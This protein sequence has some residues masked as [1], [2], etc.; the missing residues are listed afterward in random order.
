MK[1]AHIHTHTHTR[2]HAHTHTHTHTQKEKPKRKTKRKRNR[3]NSS[4]VYFFS[5]LSFSSQ[6]HPP[7]IFTYGQFLRGVAP[8]NGAATLNKLIGASPRKN[9]EVASRR[10]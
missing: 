4:S 8:P 10:N 1:H 2:T 9:T 6:T 3:R 7:S 5:S